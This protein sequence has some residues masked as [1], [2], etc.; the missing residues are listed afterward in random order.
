MSRSDPAHPSADALV[1]PR[2]Q[3]D[4]SATED[5]MANATKNPP[6]ISGTASYG[7]LAPLGEALTAVTA[8][9]LAA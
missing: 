6:A 1:P 4:W 3:P 7:E 8:A 9:G 5:Y 2:D